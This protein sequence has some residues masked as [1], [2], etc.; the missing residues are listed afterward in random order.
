MKASQ[1]EKFEDWMKVLNLYLNQENKKLN[2]P[3][4]I[5]G[6]AFQ[7]KVWKYLQKIPYG[8]T[9]SYTEVADAIGCPKAVRAVAGA[10]AKNKI[11]LVIPCH[12]VLRGTGHLAG[13]R[14]GLKRK[15][16]LLK[17]EKN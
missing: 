2:L 9:L 15:E 12:R 6:T 17:L 13:Y 10:C 4:D 14:W 11:A 3:L 5:Q 1:K 16:K 8:K 7:I